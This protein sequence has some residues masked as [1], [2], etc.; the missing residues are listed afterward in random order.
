[1]VSKVSL[2]RC[3]IEDF[4]EESGDVIRNVSKIKSEKV[5]VI[6]GL[7]TL[8]DNLF[9]APTIEDVRY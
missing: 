5:E 7:F 3:H 4:F 1:V 9:F 8:F 6:K 2:H